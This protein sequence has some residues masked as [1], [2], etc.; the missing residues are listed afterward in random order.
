MKILIISP[1][2]SGIGGVAQIVKNQINFL[3]KNGHEIDVISSENTPIIPVKGLKNP[4]FMISSFIKT[5]FK[6]KY[7]IVHAHN[8]ISGPAMNNIQGKKIISIWGIYENQIEYLYGKKLGKISGDFERKVLSQA[9]LITVASINIKN[10]YQKLGFDA[11]YLPIGVELD[12]LPNHSKRLYDNQV[13]FVGRLQKEKGILELLKIIKEIP[14]EIHVLIVGSG[15]EEDKVKEIVKNSENLHYMGYLPREKIIPLMRG[16]DFLIQPSLIEGGL[17]TVIIEAMMCKTPVL[18]TKLEQYEEE[19]IHLEN[20]FCIEPGNSRELLESI[21]FLS[22]DKDLQKK[23]SSK[24]FVTV[25]KFSLDNMNKK[26][27]E[28]YENILK[29]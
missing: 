17:N 18:L 15:P 12:S 14:K 5:K 29:I 19:I 1:T 6:K 28:I 22:S 3:R 9:D 16:S 21:K 10:Y 20:A 4:S 25:Q 27:L 11:T 24:A 23:L 13:I 7:D 8:P 2:Q 26:F